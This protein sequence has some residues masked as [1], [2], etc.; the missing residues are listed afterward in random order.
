MQLRDEFRAGRVLDAVCGP[1]AR[2]VRLGCVGGVRDGRG[3]SVGALVRVVRGEGD[4]G[5]GVPV[6]GGY[7]EDEGEGEESVGRGDYGASV[8]DGEAAVLRCVRVRGAG[9]RVRWVGLGLTGG[10][11]SSWRSTI[12]SAGLKVSE[13][14]LVVGWR[15]CVG[16]IAELQS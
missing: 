8:W 9:G 16:R 10:Q 2:L 7:F 11:K 5:C 6:F 1:E 15:G 4:V 12:M 14:I 13:L 3:G